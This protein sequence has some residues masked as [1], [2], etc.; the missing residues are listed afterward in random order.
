MAEH[1][2]IVFKDEPTGRRAALAL[3]ADAWEVVTYIKKS[4]ERGA[5]A[6]EAAAAAL[7]LP[8]ARVRALFEWAP[9]NS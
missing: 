8:A 4:E 2:G 9:A 6:I 1:R 7:C 3:G 5:S